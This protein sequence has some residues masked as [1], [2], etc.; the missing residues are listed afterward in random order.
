[1]VDWCWEGNCVRYGRLF[2]SV[3]DRLVTLGRFKC[4]DID[5]LD[6][7]FTLVETTPEEVGFERD[8]GKPDEC[9]AL[10][11]FKFPPQFPIIIPPRLILDVTNNVTNSDLAP[12][13]VDFELRANPEIDRVA[14]VKTIWNFGDGS[15]LV[16]TEG[17]FGSAPGFRQ[18]HTYQNPVN[19]NG[20]VTLQILNVNRQVLDSETSTFSGI[21]LAEP[22]F[23]PL[24]LIV[25]VFAD[26]DIA[27]SNVML[28]I[29]GN[30]AIKDIT[31][32]YGD[33]SGP[34]TNR[35][36]KIYFS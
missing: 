16:E 30:Q 22:V 6:S 28:E 17:L 8:D 9:S 15:P 2:D 12:Q 13:D 34:T 5:K 24:T 25:D 3:R 11:D 18:K 27:P 14:I 4:S 31:I 36:F 29:I 20:T 26:S 23:T 10:N 1:M 21:I 33:G 32:D 35:T 7:R 19:F